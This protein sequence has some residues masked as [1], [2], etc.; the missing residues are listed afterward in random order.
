[1]LTK[2]DSSP[3]V[4]LADQLKAAGMRSVQEDCCW[5]KCCYNEDAA[6]HNNCRLPPADRFF[7]LKSADSGHQLYPHWCPTFYA[8]EIV[9]IP[10][11]SG[12]VFSNDQDGSPRNTDCVS[13]QFTKEAIAKYMQP[14]SCQNILDSDYCFVPLRA[15]LNA[16]TLKSIDIPL[17]VYLETTSTEGKSAPLWGGNPHICAEDVISVDSRSGLDN[18]CV[19]RNYQSVLHPCRCMSLHCAPLLIYEADSQHLCKLTTQRWMGVPPAVITRHM[20]SLVQ[21]NGNVC[22]PPP[23]EQDYPSVLQTLFSHNN[24]ANTSTPVDAVEKL[25]TVLRETVQFPRHVMNLKEGIT[26]HFRPFESTW[27]EN[28]AFANSKITTN[29]ESFPQGLFFDCTLYGVFLPNSVAQ[30]P[31]VQ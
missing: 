24:L 3:F 30:K 6:R 9:G 14:V 5:W 26:V 27:E 21:A 19:A 28:H 8:D 23:A 1:M 22:I 20:G 16:C 10:L 29:Q 4:A 17:E 18:R 7:K 12:T 11:M 31:S 25:M 2:A 15:E 13:F